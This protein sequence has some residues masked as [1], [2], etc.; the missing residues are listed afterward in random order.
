MAPLF[1]LAV[2]ALTSA[3]ACAVGVRWLGLPADRIGAA[4]LGACQLAGVAIVFLA[5]NLALGLAVVLLA[6]GV[7]RVFVSVYVL[8]DVYV[9]LLSVIQAVVFESWR[10][11]RAAR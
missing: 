6:R 9:P 4:V 2:V 5:L 11:R 10:L 8:D 3:G 1:L 7:F